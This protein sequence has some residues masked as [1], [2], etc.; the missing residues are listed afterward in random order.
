MF[1]LDTPG[2]LQKVRIIPCDDATFTPNGDDEYEVAIN[3]ET[4]TEKLEI[5]YKENTAPGTDGGNLEFERIKPQTID[6]NLLF[7]STG[8]IRNEH[9]FG[10]NLFAEAEIEPVNDQI[11]RF[12]KVVSDY[13]GNTHEPK[14][15]IVVWGNMPRIFKGRLTSLEI[16]YKLFKADGTPI[17]ATAKLSLK[18][19]IDK[20][21]EE[22][23]KNTSS[24]DLT[25]IRTVRAGETLPLMTKRIY[26]SPK[27]YLE[28][29]RVNQLDDFRNLTPGT[30]LYFPPLDKTS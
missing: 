27:Y 29:A 11:E 4:F 5:Q 28:V 18:G 7:D 3:P 16:V 25:H 26:G 19:A 14:Y 17:R 20:L 24:P 6:L 12:R 30:K 22:L 21:T 23:K 8:V 13:D 2:E 9:S 15:I 1:G 10:T